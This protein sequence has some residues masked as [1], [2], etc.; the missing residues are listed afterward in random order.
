MTESEK[1]LSVGSSSIL[2]SLRVRFE[3]RFIFF[4]TENWRFG[5]FPLLP[6]GVEFFDPIASFEVIPAP[7]APSKLG[8]DSCIPPDFDYFES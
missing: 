4:S 3:V 2:G 6:R 8:R 5:E 7:L 1:I